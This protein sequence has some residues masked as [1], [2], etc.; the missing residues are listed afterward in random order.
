MDLQRTNLLERT[1]RPGMYERSGV[2]W[3]QLEAGAFETRFSFLEAGPIIISSRS[4]NVGLKAAATLVPNTSLLAVAA[5]ARTRARCL[6]REFGSSSIALARTSNEMSTAGP[7]SFCSVLIHEELL[8]RE[9]ATTPD[10]LALLEKTQKAQLADD[11][12][13]ANRLRTAIMRFFY[14]LH[15]SDESMLPAG[16]PAKSVYGLLVP[17]V[18]DALERFDTHRSEGSKCLTK[19]LAAVRVCESYMHEHKDEP[20]TLLDL[21]RISG[22]TSRSLTNAFEAVTGFTPADYLRRLRLTGAHRALVLADRRNTKVTDVATAWG[23]WHLGHF[24]QNYRKMFGET[25]SQTLLHS[26]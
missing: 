16:L 10:V 21:S 5:D 11:P 3:S 6:G 4:Y 19:R 20:V 13:H 2:T 22:F 24:S 7:S 17:L 25:P 8:A 12:F 1:W 23:F 9:F 15:E 26:R 18:A 14:L